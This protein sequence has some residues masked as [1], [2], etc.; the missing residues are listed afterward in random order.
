MKS[1]IEYQFQNDN[2]LYMYSYS[3]IQQKYYNVIVL[4]VWLTVKNGNLSKTYIIIILFVAKR[5][6]R[7]RG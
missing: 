7:E 1:N 5:E 3:Y 2:E 6:K 4:G